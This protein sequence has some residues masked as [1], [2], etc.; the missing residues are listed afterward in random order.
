MERAS[1]GVKHLVMTIVMENKNRSEIFY[2]YFIDFLLC[3]AYYNYRN[4][5]ISGEAD[6]INALLVC[7]V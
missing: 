3:F 2:K 7:E 1:H 5:M 4:R 6:S